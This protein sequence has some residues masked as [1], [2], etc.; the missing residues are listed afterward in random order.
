MNAEKPTVLIVDDE[1]ISRSVLLELLQDD[2][3]IILAKNG[4]QALERLREHKPDLILLDVVMP[5]MDGYQ[6]IRQIKED[7]SIRHI[8]VIFISGLDS[9]EDET[10][11]LS[12][13]AADYITKPFHMPIVRMRVRNHL[14][15]VHQRRLLEQLALVDSLTEIANRRCFDQA[16]EQEWLRCMRVNIPLSL[17]MIDVDNFK[18]YNDHYGHAAGDIVLRRVANCL[19]DILKRPGDLVARFGGEEFVMLLP[20]IDAS[21]GRVFAEQACAAV[22][23]LNILHAKSG[24]ANCVTVSMGGATEMPISGNLSGMLLNLADTRLYEAKKSGRNRLVWDDSV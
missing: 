9:V 13:G 19:S 1:K 24:A 4:K 20:G 10:L 17:V 14:Q 3:R 23:N 22:E 12:L 18:K 16:L 15:F 6:V 5:E 11:G 21:S 2:C 8:P 7:D